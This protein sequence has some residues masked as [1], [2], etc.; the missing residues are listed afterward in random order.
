M[1]TQ[2][3]S[4]EAYERRPE[5][6]LLVKLVFENPKDVDGQVIKDFVR[7]MEEPGNFGSDPTGADYIFETDLNLQQD[8][9]DR[10]TQLNEQLDFVNGPKRFAVLPFGIRDDVDAPDNYSHARHDLKNLMLTGQGK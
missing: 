10:I 8:L 7:R 6:S 4:H 2:P 9:S 1:I 5:Y 3:E